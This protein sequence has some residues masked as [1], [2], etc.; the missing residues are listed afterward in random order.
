MGKAVEMND[1]VERLGYVGQIGAPKALVLSTESKKGLIREVDALVEF[2]IIQHKLGVLLL[3][4]MT[5]LPLGHER[6]V[7]TGSVLFAQEDNGTC[8]KSI[9][10]FYSPAPSGPFCELPGCSLLFLCLPLKAGNTIQA[11][12][13][14]R[15]QPLPPQWPKSACAFQTGSGFDI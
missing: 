5:R 8:T 3:V 7:L 10:T 15:H 2:K 14:H 13:S 4:T 6:N 12:C 9:A 11:R 1:A